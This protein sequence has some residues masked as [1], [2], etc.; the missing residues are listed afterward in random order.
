MNINKINCAFMKGKFPQGMKA[1][2]SDLDFEKI[3]KTLSGNNVGSGHSRQ[4]E[5]N[6]TR[7]GR[8][9]DC[10]KFGK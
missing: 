1:V 3:I 4:T 2:E 6:E 7:H 9:I 8:T 5:Q 10:E